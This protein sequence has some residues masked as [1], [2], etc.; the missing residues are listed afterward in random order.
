MNIL[1]ASRTDVGRVRT[2]NE[3][4][5]YADA[6]AGLFIVCDG[7]GGHSAGEVASRICCETL[8][9]ELPG[10][11]ALRQ[12]YAHSHNQSDVK[13]LCAG[14]EQAMGVAC[15]EI[16]KAASRS[17]QMMREVLARWTQPAS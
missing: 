11:V 15:K 17:P 7:M 16:N 13:A 3:D 5:F 10:L 12:T 14:V 4:K 2:N 9:K 8:V 1:A 6:E